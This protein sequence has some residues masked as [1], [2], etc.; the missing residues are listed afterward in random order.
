MKCCLPRMR[1]LT[2]D[3]LEEHAYG[4]VD[5]DP[6]ET[7]VAQL[8]LADMRRRDEA[9]MLRERNA[10]LTR[11]VGELASMCRGFREEEE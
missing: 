8:L 10:E 9:E 3:E 11:S 4:G 7:E 5:C 1:T 6:C 2:V